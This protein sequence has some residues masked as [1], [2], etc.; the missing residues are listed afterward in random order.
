V[1]VVNVDKIAREKGLSFDDEGGEDEQ[2]GG[3]FD[4]RG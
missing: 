3:E 4:D 1:R 2:G